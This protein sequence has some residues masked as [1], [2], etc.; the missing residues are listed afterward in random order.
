MEQKLSLTK[1]VK[2]YTV[3]DVLAE[4]KEDVE[5]LA[6]IGYPEIKKNKYTIKINQKRAHSLG[7]CGNGTINYTGT[8]FNITY[9]NSDYIANAHDYIITINGYHLKLSPAEEVHNTIMH[10]VIH[11]LPGCMNHGEKWKYAANRVNHFYEFPKIK[12][13]MTL[14]DTKHGDYISSTFK[15]I[16]ECQGCHSKHRF[17]RESKTVRACKAGRAQCSCG[18]KNFLVTENF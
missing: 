1:E 7:R 8:G 16:I 10:E 13:C 4:V 17:M 2:N 14:D 12:R 15:Y 11:S 5:L 3:N 18:S 6:A 9:D